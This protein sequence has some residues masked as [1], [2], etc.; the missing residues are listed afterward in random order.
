[1]AVVLG[2]VLNSLFLAVAPEHALT[3]ERAQ[4]VSIPPLRG[5]VDF[6]SHGPKDVFGWLANPV[7]WSSAAVIAIIAS[8][9]TLLCLEATD[10]LDPFK[11]VS[12]PNR[13]LVAQGIGNML[14][15]ASGGIP[16]TS[17]IVRSSA[18]IY[19]GARTRI[20][21][22][23]HGFLL[24]VSVL[25]FP[26]MLARIPLASLA[27]IL[28]VVGYKLV[29]RKIL[30]QVLASGY[31]QFLPFVVT[32]G[33]VVMF[34]LLSGVLIG[35]VIGLLVVLIMNHHR[36]FTLVG[37]GSSF[38]LRFAKDVTFLQKIALKR[39]LARIPN[40]AS[41]VIDGS[42]AMFIDRD[43]AEL[44]EDFQGSAVQRGIEV[45]LRNM[46]ERSFDLLHVLGKRGS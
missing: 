46:P 7:V 37:S 45:L 38:Y 26:G 25:A 15:G 27:A 23:I 30:Q 17:V 22:I 43:I 9:E 21:G 29:N 39:A 36:A 14:A 4:L 10:K 24:L 40:N 3:L 6:F 16:M 31:D 41:I 42:G 12:R 33:C 32:A 11:R 28:I 34:D 13:E 18:N 44:V 5:F 35:T 2:V 8:V 1:L 19:A 20:S